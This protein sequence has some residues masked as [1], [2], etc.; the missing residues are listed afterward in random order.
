[1]PFLLLEKERGRT[2]F[3]NNEERLTLWK[4]WVDNMTKRNS[5]HQAPATSDID[6]NNTLSLSL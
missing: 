5:D 4:S 1:M 3:P 2:A 6:R